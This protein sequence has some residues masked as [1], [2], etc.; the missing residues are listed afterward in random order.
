MTSPC[1]PRAWWRSAK[2]RRDQSERNSALGGALGTKAQRISINAI[3]AINLPQKKEKER[4]RR[5]CKVSQAFHPKSIDQ[6]A[7]EKGDPQWL[8]RLNPMLLRNSARQKREHRAPCLPEAG[9]PAYR[10]REDPAGQDAP[11]LVHGDGVHGPEQDA[12][13]GYGDGVADQGGH[14]PDGEREAGGKGKGGHQPQMRGRR[15]AKTYAMER[16]P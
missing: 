1:T 9:D 11:G 12:D 10:A 4:A 16:M 13:D 8:Q 15:G 2:D 3:I 7:Q 14:E 5:P 6:R